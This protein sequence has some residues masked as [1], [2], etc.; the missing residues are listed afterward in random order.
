MV[1]LLNDVQ[2]ANITVDTNERAAFLKTTSSTEHAATIYQAGTSGVDTAAALN[3]VSDNSQSSA[4]Y[5]SGTET[6]RGTL[7]IAHRGST[8][9]ADANAAALSIDLQDHASG[10]SAAQGLFISGVTTGRR[11][12]VR[13]NA[14]VDRFEVNGTGNMIT[15]AAA[16]I[17]NGMQVGSTSTQF[18]GGAGGIIGVTNA[19]TAPTT[20]PTGGVVVYSEGGVLKYRDP[21]GNVVVLQSASTLVPRAETY[22]AAPTGVQKSLTVSYTTDVS[23]PNIDEVSVGGELT[24]WRN[25]DGL[26]R[27]KIPAHKLWDS[28]FRARSRSGQTGLHWAIETEASVEFYGIDPVD[29]RP[30]VEGVKYSNLQTNAGAVT[31]GAS[32]AVYGVKFLTTTPESCTQ[33]GSGSALASQTVYLM[34][35]E[36]LTPVTVSS[37]RSYVHA[38]G[39]TPTAGY[40]GYAI[41][42]ESGSILTLVAATP[43]DTALFTT[44]L[45]RSKSFTTPINLNPG[46]YWIGI[47]SRCATAPQMRATAASLPGGLF[48][49]MP[50]GTTVASI[51]S[52]SVFPASLDKTTWGAGNLAFRFLMAAV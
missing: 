8:A 11:I 12:R 21:S 32:P 7:K 37:I 44:T 1:K 36:I 33:G 48:S 2:A 39:V 49:G 14:S 6:D 30:V 29:G 45:W 41:Y 51:A 3:V 52:Q 31:A 18:G 46:I 16:L 20:N 4:M 17:N 28:P 23:D 10:G 26:W 38:A 13:D 34:K 24:A 19:S 40:N 22:S 5:L 47:M 42:S 50:A 15:R 27:G 25:E 9:A 43:D 35:Q